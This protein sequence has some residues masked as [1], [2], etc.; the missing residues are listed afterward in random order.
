MQPGYLHPWPHN[1][2]R[3]AIKYRLGGIPV[4]W[5][6]EAEEKSD[7]N[8]PLQELREFRAV[9]LFSEHRSQG[10]ALVKAGPIVGVAFFGLPFLAKQKR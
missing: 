4:D 3:E 2:H 8:G 5:P 7:Q 1:S 9:P 10:G 6:R